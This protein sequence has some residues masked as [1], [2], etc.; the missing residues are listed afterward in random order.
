VPAWL[1]RAAKRCVLIGILVAYVAPLS[2]VVSE[3]LN[4]RYIDTL[5]ERHLTAMEAYK[6]DLDRAQTQ[7]IALRE[8]ISVLRPGESMEEIRAGIIAIA[9][10]VYNAF[11]SSLTAFL[12]YILTVLFE[13]V[14]FPLLSA[15]I[16]YK[17]T[18]WALGRL[19][20][21]FAPSATAP[22]PAT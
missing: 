17:F 18:E 2:I 11:Q 4:E 6:K 16:L 22:V 15:L 1:S 19:L 8:K 10:G 7:F 12:F 9:E 3:S 5:K 21:P 20:N 13:L 14:V